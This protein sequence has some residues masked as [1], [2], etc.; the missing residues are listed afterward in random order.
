METPTSNQPP[1]VDQRP[2]AFGA[3]GAPPLTKTS[4]AVGRRSP[5]SPRRR[6]HQSLL[7]AKTAFVRIAWLSPFKFSRRSWL[8]S[9]SIF[10]KRTRDYIRRTSHRSRGSIPSSI[11]TPTSS[12]ST[13]TPQPQEAVLPLVLLFI[14]L[15]GNP[16]PPPHWSRVL[17]HNGGPNQYK[18]CVFLCCE[19]VEF[20]RKILES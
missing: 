19:F 2:H 5:W 12:L 8:P 3:R 14:I 18:S 20:I 10:G 1:R 4:R 6:H 9:R 13:S 17:H 16:P 15:R 11:L 7:Q